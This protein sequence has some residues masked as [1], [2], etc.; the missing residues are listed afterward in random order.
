MYDDATEWLEAAAGRRSTR[1]GKASDV[2]RGHE[3]HPS[4]LPSNLAHSTLL[5]LKYSQEE[6][7]KDIKI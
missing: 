5:A 2:T 4:V 7:K 6:R 3:T 1:L